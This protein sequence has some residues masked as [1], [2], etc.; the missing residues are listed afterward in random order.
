MDRV[1]DPADPKRCTGAVAEGQCWSVAEPGCDRCR[2]HG[3]RD[4]EAVEDKRLYLL[5]KAQ[6]R[7]RLAQLS[8]HEQIKSL[9]DEIALARMLIEER[10]N[11]VKNDSDLISAFGPI[12]TALLTVER[13]VKSAHSIEQ[14]LGALLSKPT[15][16]ALGQSISQVIVE[17]LEGVDDYEAIVDRI[18]HRIVEA[19]VAAGTTATDNN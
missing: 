5:T 6:H 1:K 3:G 14:N 15:V 11:K 9:R 18:N 2:V 12:N 17:E 13:L 19:I 16:L 4:K 10:F 8:E 7:M